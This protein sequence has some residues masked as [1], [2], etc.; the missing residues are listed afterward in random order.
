M[1]CPYGPY[2][3]SS[4]FLTL[5]FW[6]SWVAAQ[7]MQGDPRNGHVIDEQHC[8]RCHGEAGRGDGLEGEFLIVPPA[9]LQSPGSRAKADWELLVIISHGIAFSPMHAWR[10][11][12]TEEEMWDVI[13][14]IRFIAPFNP[15]A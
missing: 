3:G 1:V 10:D 4:L 6:G 12:L 15:A 7:G 5:I 8:L 11:R 9:N 13:A 14:Y 2:Q